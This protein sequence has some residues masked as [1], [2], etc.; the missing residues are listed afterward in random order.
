M[1]GGTLMVW[2]RVCN[3]SIGVPAAMRPMTGTATGRLPSSS[4]PPP[5]LLLP[6][7]TLPRVPSMTL[8]VK[9]RRPLPLPLEESSGSLMTSMARARLGRR[10]MKPRSSKAVI[11]RWIPDFD[12]KS[13]ASFISSKEG[14]TPHSF[15]RSLMNRSSSYC[16]RVSIST[17]P[18]F[19]HPEA[20]GAVRFRDAGAND[21]RLQASI[22]E[23]NHE[24]T[25]YV[26]Y[27]FRNHL[28]S[29]QQIE[30]LP[31]RRLMRSAGQP[32]EAA[33]R[34]CGCGGRKRRTDHKRL[35]RSEIPQQRTVLM[36]DRCGHED[37][38]AA[39]LETGAQIIFAHVVGG[40]GTPEQRRLADVMDVGAAG[41]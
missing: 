3:A 9:P 29:R 10:R 25:L 15:R 1:S 41:Q 34:P 14:G 20:D 39:H 24:R 40:N 23:T 37:A 12:R 36:V 2:L 38:I 17:N 32:Q 30:A 16:L 4:E 28:I 13:S 26:P 18:Q 35:C 11:R 6:L 7:R 19:F 22:L 31:K 5:L 33:G 21:H 27:V 8:G